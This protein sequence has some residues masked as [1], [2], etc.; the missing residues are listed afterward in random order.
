MGG[1]VLEWG[2]RIVTWLLAEQD[3]R[4]FVPGKGWAHAIAHGADALAALARSPHASKAELTVVL[5]VIA[6]RVLSPVDHWLVHG[7]PDRLAV[8]TMDV[9]RRNR[10]PLQ[11]LEPWV[12][13][14]A[15]TASGTSGR[16][17]AAT[18]RDPFMVAGNAEAFLRGLYLQ[19]A[20]GPQRPELRSDL[21]L[22]VVE[23]LRR[24][25]PH[26]FALAPPVQ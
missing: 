3:L 11:V 1:K 19:L 21:L 6:D 13:R 23:A 20:L 26:Y 10:V 12:A 17:G 18:E 15:A 16:P 22:V 4:G 25:N 14:I 8:A 5:D 9:L 7:E 2:D 24:S